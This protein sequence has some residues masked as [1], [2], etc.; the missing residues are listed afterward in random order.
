MKIQ[1]KNAQNVFKIQR[2]FEIIFTTIY[3]RQIK[4]FGL[5]KNYGFDLKYFKTFSISFGAVDRKISIFKPPFFNCINF[6]YPVL[7]L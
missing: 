3:K 6:L 5:T 2:Y 4:I 1:E 7:K